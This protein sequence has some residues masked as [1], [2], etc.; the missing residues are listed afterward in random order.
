MKTILNLIQRGTFVG[1]GFRP[2]LLV[3]AI[4]TWA[5]AALAQTPSADDS[6]NT[7]AD[8]SVGSLLVQADGKILIIGASTNIVARLNAD[9]TRDTGFNVGTWDIIATGAGGIA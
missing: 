2:T 8:Y 9:G 1:V 7:G 3:A 6:F 5:L 4:S